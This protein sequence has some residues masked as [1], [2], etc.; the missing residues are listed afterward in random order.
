MTFPRVPRSFIVL[1]RILLVAPMLV[2]VT[3]ANAGNAQ[4]GGSGAFFRAP[5]NVSRSPGVSRPARVS[6]RSLVL[7][8]A[9]SVFVIWVENLPHTEGIAHE[10]ASCRYLAG[11]GWDSAYT[12]IGRW[13]G[14]PST[15]PAAVLDRARVLHLVWLEHRADSRQVMALRFDLT[16]GIISEDEAVSPLARSVADPAAALDLEGRLHVVWSVIESTKPGLVYRRFAP[17]GWDS[18]RTLAT[19]DGESAFGP[20][21][22][23]SAEGTVHVAWQRAQSRGNAVMYAALDPGGSLGTPERVSQGE[24]G[25]FAG[26]PVLAAA[27]HDVWVV[28]SETDGTEARVLARRRR[29]AGFD[30]ALAVSPAGTVAEHPSMAAD[31]WGGVHVAWVERAEPSSEGGLP[32]V[33]VASLS[34]GESAF[35]PARPL[36]I[37]S[38]GPVEGVMV[39]TDTAGRVAVSWVDTG[40]GAGDIMLRLGVAG[41]A[42]PSAPVP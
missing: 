1:F 30:R 28:W 29:A 34:P 23:C 33:M 15:E 24:A 10:L 7:D 41:F 13:E 4:T 25:W 8:P 11:T 40:A 37:G 36:S 20:D 14:A 16:T 18:T 3:L 42:P 32:R 27:G 12:P 21:I 6:P 9:G 17:A 38:V 26:A 22:A 2:L 39:A 19:G 31:P 5:V 35:S